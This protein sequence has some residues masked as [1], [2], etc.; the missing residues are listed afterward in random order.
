MKKLI[1]SSDATNYFLFFFV[2]FAVMSHAK[3][4]PRPLAAAAKSRHEDY[5]DERERTA[6]L[7]FVFSFF[8]L[9]REFG[10]PSSDGSDSFSSRQQQGK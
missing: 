2:L 5:L 3:K 1:Y 9:V 7:V 8:F 4:K 10:K 6:S